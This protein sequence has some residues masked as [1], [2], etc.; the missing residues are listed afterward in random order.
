M[1]LN[2][3]DGRRKVER[4]EQTCVQV[5]INTFVR[6]SYN[7]LQ[8]IIQSSDDILYISYKKACRRILAK[9]RRYSLLSETQSQ[10]DTET[11]LH[12]I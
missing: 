4:D 3:K 9:E 2:S 7:T 5:Y 11:L 12:N 10:T 8:R 6:Y 1:R